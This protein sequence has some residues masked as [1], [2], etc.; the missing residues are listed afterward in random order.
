MQK[1]LAS[2]LAPYNVTINSV[3]PGYI[4]TDR[5]RNLAAKKSEETGKSIEETLKSMG[6]NAPAGTL[7]E[8][9]DIAAAVA[10]LA[11]ELAR[12]ITGNTIHVDG[13]LV[14]ALL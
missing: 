3:A 9:L 14:K 11:S 2:E 10:F 7:G 8:P 1:T 12:Y 4:L 6:E 5:L 13:G